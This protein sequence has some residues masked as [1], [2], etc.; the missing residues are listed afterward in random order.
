MWINVN[1]DAKLNN[2]LIFPNDFENNLLK[3][4]L[5]KPHE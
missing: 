2:V 3:I 1:K 5:Q 4:R